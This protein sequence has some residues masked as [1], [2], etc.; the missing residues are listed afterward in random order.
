MERPLLEVFTTSWNERNTILELIN[1][2]RSLV[3]DCLIHVQD[4]MSTD[5]TKQVCKENNVKFTT[6]DTNNQ[7]DENTLI[8]LRNSSW[9][10]STAYYVIV[11]DSDELVE[12][13]K[14]KL[15]ENLKDLKW[16]VAKC[17]GIELF[18]NDKSFKDAN[19]GVYSEGYS[20]KVLWLKDAIQQSSLAPGSHSATFIPNKGFEILYSQDPPVLYHTKWIDYKS[21]IA[22]QN[23]I[24]QKGVSQHSKS[25]GWNFHYGL[26]ESSHL[27]YWKKGMEN[28]IKVK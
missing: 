18:G 20:K 3:P 22:R 6:F 24:K 10:N 28:R 12:I 15:V 1:F 8:H 5:D 25:R 2:Y 23:Q 14:D 16:T 27:D 11:C 26:P 19:Y 17:K 9:K 7:M 13:N 21:G 4:N